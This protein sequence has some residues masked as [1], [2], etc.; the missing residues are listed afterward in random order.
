M[1]ML[2]S[3]EEVIAELGG[4]KAVAELTKRASPSAVPNW[5]ARKAFPTDTYAIMK[6]ALAAKDAAAPGDL[7]RMPEAA[8]PEDVAS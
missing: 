2:A 8:E 3:I 6:S 7:W 5:K 1:R 4:I